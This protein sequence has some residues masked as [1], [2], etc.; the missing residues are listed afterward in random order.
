M[1]KQIMDEELD[2]KQTWCLQSY[3]NIGEY[4]HH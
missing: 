2:N 3:D 4:L 1:V